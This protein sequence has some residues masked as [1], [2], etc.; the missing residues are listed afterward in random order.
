MSNKMAWIL[1]I[2]FIAF[3][4][5][6]FIFAN[7]QVD[8]ARQI[9]SQQDVDRDISQT[10]S[11][12]QQEK[13]KEYA[14]SLGRTVEEQQAA[15]KAEADRIAFEK[16]VAP[17][18]YITYQTYDKHNCQWCSGRGYT[19]CVWCDGCGRQWSA[20]NNQFE[21]CWYC[22]GS[23]QDP[24][25]KCCGQGSFSTLSG[26]SQ[27]LNPTYIDWAKRHKKPAWEDRECPQC[28]GQG[29]FWGQ[30]K[31][32]KGIG[33]ITIHE[34]EGYTTSLCPACAKFREENGDDYDTG[35]IVISCSRC[36]GT[37]EIKVDVTK[38]K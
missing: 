14:A 32:C 25:A 34:G 18:Q 33:Y 20:V 11:L 28:K 29:N 37:G 1:V 31:Q 16:E 22:K 26:T 35:V 19:T 30:C 36:K 23:G 24:C 38:E 3:L 13:Y 7:N 4:I 21:A 12:I 9:L 17:A 15:E 6:G 8:S 27:V 2:I 10:A 5:V